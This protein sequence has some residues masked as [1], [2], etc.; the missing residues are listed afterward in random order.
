VGRLRSLPIEALQPEVLASRLRAQLLSG[1]PAAG[2][3]AVARR[4]LAL[5]GQDARGVRLAIRSRTRGLSA[6]AVDDALTVERSLVLTWLCRGTLHLVR[7]ED[8][9]W[10]HAL[11][12]PG[13]LAGARRR[14][15]ELGVGERAAER[16]VAA[17]ARSLEADGPLLRAELRERVAAAGVRSEGQ[18]IVHLLVLASQR[19]L[20]V[21]G[22]MRGRE[23]AFV[24]VRDWLGELPRI[25]RERALAELARRYLEGH[26][27]ASDADLA[28]WSGLGLRE[29][30]AGLRAIGSELRPRA[31]GLAQ[32][33]TAPRARSLPA[34][35]LLGAF[36]PILHGW[37][38][39]APILGERGRGVVTVN[40]I[41]RP[42]ALVGG[43][44]VATWSFARGR[45][46]LA[47]LEP[48][49]D[50]DAEALRRDGLDVARFLR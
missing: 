26:G 19:G 2:P 21:R 16:G 50:A 30:R 44:A 34:P 36:D 27:P 1:G 11:T 40:G 5:Q 24:L 35:R 3:V 12:A 38:S 43:R 23:Q 47:P 46:E 7:R 13:M 10:L 42:F 32:L 41:F 9:A 49:R 6:A 14:L 17:I 18:A 8:Y 20:I 33:A 22:P 28:G 29:V 48:I 4:I 45:V 15:A 39:R 25:D 31:D 37:R